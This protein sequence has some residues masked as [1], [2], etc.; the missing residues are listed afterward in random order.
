MEVVRRHL[1]VLTREGADLYRALLPAM[2]SMANDRGTLSDSDRDRM[3][4]FLAEESVP[5]S[6]P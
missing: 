2:L 5:L 1:E 3:V 6:D 4:A